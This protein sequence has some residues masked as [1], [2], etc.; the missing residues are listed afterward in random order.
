MTHKTSVYL[1]CGCTLESNIDNNLELFTKDYQ[2][3]Y[4]SDMRND[5]FRKSWDYQHQMLTIQK[6]D[7][8]HA[9]FFPSLGHTK[10][11]IEFFL[12]KMLSC[13]KQMCYNYYSIN[14]TKIPNNESINEIFLKIIKNFIGHQKNIEFAFD[15]LFSNAIDENF[16]TLILPGQKVYFYNDL[17][18]RYSLICK[19]SEDLNEKKIAP[20]FQDCEN[21]LSSAF[22][23]KCALLKLIECLKVF[24]VSN[25]IMYVAKNAIQCFGRDIVGRMKNLIDDCTNS[26]KKLNINDTIKNY[27]YIK[28][29]LMKY[30]NYCESLYCPII[31]SIADEICELAKTTRSESVTIATVKIY[32]KYLTEKAEKIIYDIAANIHTAKDVDGK[33]FYSH[34]VES[35]DTNRNNLLKIFAIVKLE[36]SKIGYDVTIYENPNENLVSFNVDF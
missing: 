16:E 21:F 3:N 15:K 6:D 31:N 18:N 26:D 34:P 25:N 13:I 20:V 14:V 32:D 23:F 22:K 35:C 30:K 10:N 1:S 36:L 9:F 4:L 7:T 33:Y 11:K 27:E 19:I 5:L 8:N 29:N 2:G 17:I 12:E 28:A 24:I